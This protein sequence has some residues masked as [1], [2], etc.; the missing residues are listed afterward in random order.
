M[1]DVNDAINHPLASN[2][3]VIVFD[4]ENYVLDGVRKTSMSEVTKSK[5]TTAGR[6]MLGIYDK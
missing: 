6:Y 4:P 3:P 5:L 2:S 1:L